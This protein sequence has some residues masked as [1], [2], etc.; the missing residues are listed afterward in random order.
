L[1]QPPPPGPQGIPSAWSRRINEACSHSS[2][3]HMRIL[4]PPSPN[5]CAP[6]CATARTAAA[7]RAYRRNGQGR[8]SCPWCMVECQRGLAPVLTSISQPLLPPTLLFGP[9]GWTGPRYGTHLLCARSQPLLAAYAGHSTV[10][11]LDLDK[12]EVLHVLGPH[13]ARCAQAVYARSK[14]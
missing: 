3:N 14:A 10:V 12:Q 6:S 8:G 9:H 4:F 1:F 2:E 13:H 7:L 5:W 11:V